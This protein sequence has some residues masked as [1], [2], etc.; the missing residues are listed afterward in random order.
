[1]L[2]EGL[3]FSRIAAVWIKRLGVYQAWQAA[4]LSLC[5]FA[6]LQWVSRRWSGC[7]K[8]MGLGFD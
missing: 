6:G 8:R 3:G 5:C 4:V 2:P 1:M 7:L